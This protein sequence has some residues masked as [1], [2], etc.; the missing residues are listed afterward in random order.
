MN[1]I[2]EGTHLSM[3]DTMKAALCYPVMSG[4]LAVMSESMTKA[5]GVYIAQGF[6][7]VMEHIITISMLVVCMGIVGLACFL[8]VSLGAQ[9][10]DSRYFLPAYC[11]TSSTFFGLYGVAIGEFKGH[12][13]FSSFMF[14][15]FGLVAISSVVMGSM[16]SQTSKDEQIE[17]Q[18]THHQS[19]SDVADYLD[20][21]QEPG[22]A[23]RRPGRQAR[24][25]K[26]AK[27][28]DVRESIV[29]F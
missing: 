23:G 12:P 4:C 15:V 13:P 11:A 14:G 10:F 27:L 1:K 6:T 28:V 24:A 9:K 20:E 22:Q 3:M 19:L 17:N 29:I 16:H 7:Y 26:W 21:G 2:P 25:N 8:T 18:V 5:V